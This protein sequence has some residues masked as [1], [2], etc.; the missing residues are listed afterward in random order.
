V[1]FPSLPPF[2]PPSL[3]PSLLQWKGRR[4]PSEPVKA[5]KEG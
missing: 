5:V 4:G 1:P 2:L 3:P